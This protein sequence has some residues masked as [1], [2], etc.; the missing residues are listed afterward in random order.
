MDQEQG[1]KA[2]AE[3]REQ[4]TSRVE[5]TG[6]HIHGREERVSAN[7]AEQ[8]VEMENQELVMNLD[9]EGRRELRL[10]DE[11]LARIEAGE[12]GQC[13]ACGHE[14]APERLRAI[15]YASRCIAC[16]EKLEA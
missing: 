9:A 1:R 12:W 8:S 2:L 11:A 14:I 6:K 13:V 16:E 4:L 15:P 7:F 5:R 10:I 3:L